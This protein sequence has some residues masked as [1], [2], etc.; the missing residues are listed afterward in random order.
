MAEKIPHFAT[1]SSNFKHRFTEQTIEDVFHW[2]LRE[3]TSRNVLSP[4][5]VFINGT[6]IKA[7]ANMKKRIKK[8]VPVAAKKYEKQLMEEINEERESH[9][10][11]PFSTKANTR[12]SLRMKHTRLATKTA[13]FSMSR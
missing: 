13:T 7:S 2:A 12:S 10:I 4:E 6:H 11:K 9:E 3:I 8:E 5:A 1:I